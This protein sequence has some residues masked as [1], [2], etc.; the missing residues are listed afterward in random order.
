LERIGSGQN[1]SVRTTPNQSGPH[2]ISP[3]D[4]PA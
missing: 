2:R 3:K 1:K 4:E